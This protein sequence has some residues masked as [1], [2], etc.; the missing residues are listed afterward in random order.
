MVIGYRL[1]VIGSLSWGVKSSARSSVRWTV[2]ELP[3]GEVSSYT[4]HRTLVH[5]TSYTVHYFFHLGRKITKKNAHMQKKMQNFR[6]SR[7]NST[8]FRNR[9]QVPCLCKCRL[10]RSKREKATERVHHR[11]GVYGHPMFYFDVEKLTP[12]RKILIIFTK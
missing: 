5:R 11:N 12:C 9:Q 6:K 8:F 4:V 7:V 10:F 1:L 3:R 2:V